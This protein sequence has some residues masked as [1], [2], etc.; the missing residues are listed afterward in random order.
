MFP[1][2]VPDEDALEQRLIAASI[3]LLQHPIAIREVREHGVDYGRPT[4]EQLIVAR[5]LVQPDQ[6]S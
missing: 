4:R 1:E 3:G 5:Q 2:Q 6:P